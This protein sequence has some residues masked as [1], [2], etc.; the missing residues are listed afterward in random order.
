MA[1]LINEI[2]KKNNLLD[3]DRV[4]NLFIQK[5]EE[6]KKITNSIKHD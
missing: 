2:M 3:M 4:N 6:L 5:K 1:T